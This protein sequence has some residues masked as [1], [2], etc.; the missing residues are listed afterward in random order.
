MH[1]RTMMKNPKG[2]VS[3]ASHKSNGFTL[4]ELLVVIA[5]IALLAAIL[6]PV[7]GRARENA[8]RSNCQSNMKQI[9]LGIL[10]YAQDFDEQMPLLR[11]NGNCSA[12][13]GEL[14]QPYMKSKQVF[15]C[16]SQEKDNP[17]SCSDADARVFTDY[18]A[19][20]A[21]GAV[22]NG[23]AFSYDRPLDNSNWSN[24]YTFRTT[25]LAKL[26]TPSQSIMVLEYDSSLGTGNYGVNLQTV[27]YGTG[28]WSPKGHLGTTNFLFVDGHVKSMKLSAT[29]T[30]SANM[31]SS[32]ANNVPGGGVGN[33]LRGALASQEARIG[34]Q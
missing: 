5:I 20:G 23:T 27:S 28:M 16:P 3:M 24:P 17:V 30:S 14:I 11:Q 13:W 19:N 22:G 18:I 32:N 34:A 25:P 4:I 1:R 9:G 26:E 7:F 12:P 15:R 8:R 2:A 33:A 31:W 29:F 21:R 10:Q 6:F